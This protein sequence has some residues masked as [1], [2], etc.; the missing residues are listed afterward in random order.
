MKSNFG[1]LNRYWPALAQIGAAAE[2]YVYSDANACLYKLGMFG[3]RLILEIFAFEHIK[4]PALDNTHANRI[5][6]LKQEG[7]IPKK[8]DDILYALRK[9][10]NDAVH[11]GADSVEDAKI[12]L[13]MTYNLAV[14]FM[15]VYGDWGYIAPAFVMP[16]KVMQPNYEAII[17]EQE[18]KIAALSKQ[19]ESVS[20]AVSSKTSKERAE[21]GET[22]SESIKLSE[23]ETRYLIDEQ[24]R[25]YGWE[26]DT[27]HLRYSK[28]IRP[29]KGR[30]L[31]IAEWPTDSAIGKNG[32]ADYALFVELKLVGIVE[33]KKAAVDI[34]SVI[35]Y[36]CKEYAKGIKA[37][38]R[39][40]IINQWGAYKV[41][42]VFATNGRK[43][44]KQIETKSGIWYLDLRSGANAPK[45][46]Q[47]WISPQGLMEQLEKDIAAANAALQNT[48]FDLLRD[49]DGL[50]LHKYQIAAI[51]AAEQAV[52]DGKQTVLLSMATGTGKTRTILGMIYR[53]IK[54]DR[55]KRVLFLVDRTALGE[56][57]EDVFKE[58]KIEELMTLDS[59][60]NIKG[61][62][63]K[64]IDKETKIHIA[65]VQSLVKRILYPEGDTMLSVTDYDLIVVDEAHRGYILDKEMSE[66]EMLYRNQDD[67]ISKY[68]T[69]IE[70]F[71][72]VKIALTATPALHTTEIFGKPVFNYSY[73]EAVIDGYLVDHD[74]PHNIRTK[75]RVEGIN[76]KK[77]EQLVIYDP[78][79]GDVLNSAELEDDMK[80]EI[81]SFNRQIITENF[82][83]AVFEEI[84]WDFN[85]DGQGKTLIY[86]V[87]DNHADL[88]VKILKEIYAEGGVDNDTVMKIT[89]S[90][91]GGNKKKISEA[92]KRFKNESLPKVV[93]TV[94]LLTTGIDVPEITTLVFMRRI[95]SRILFEQM[96]GR[97][98]RLCPTIG[99][100]HFEIYDPVGVYESLQDVSN[101][102]PVVTNPSASFEDL[103]KGLEVAKTDEQ[104]AYQI[105]LIVAKLQRKRRNVSKKALEQFA[106]LTGGKDLTAF[107]EYL[108]N[109]TI[110]EAAAE[111]IR[112]RE[113]FSALDKDKPHR[114]R[115]VVIDNH[116]DELIDH[117]RGYGEGQKPE[118]YLEAFKE[119]IN[120]NMNAI[121]A[122]R[123]V[124]TK[125]SELTREALKSLKLELDRHDFTEKQLNSAWNEMT[126]Q[127]IV[128]DIIAF[129]RQQALG[130]IL[131]SHEQRVN[132]AFA[133]LRVNHD[134]NKTQLDWLKR[135]EKVLLEE[136]VLDE[137]IFE[138]GAFRNAGGFTIIDR[139]FG[140][141][142]REIMT[143]LNEYLYED[144]G[145][146]A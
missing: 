135:I 2:K 71:D 85:P 106:H 41:P 6:L 37:E 70:Y 38:H 31:A 121:A 59:I 23:A 76:Y 119:F 48:P 40:Y 105:D 58:V 126:N 50:N 45:A 94:D 134:F 65:T 138:V 108:N 145:H 139:R 24:L 142:L 4:E 17:K 22:A 115:P 75:L 42:F 79:T 28:G 143:E 136:S 88:I 89:G 103:M 7:L 57:A 144:G 74:A 26:A 104:L 53:F 123:T 114:K 125:P 137:Q 27:N 118:D 1:F 107:A 98:T 19:V 14:W 127:D 32:Y 86:A 54:N 99:K 52:I 11:A 30:N 69:V 141:K 36:Q 9:T 109:S 112:H 15:E 117:T 25:K 102:K 10:R 49:P 29:Q 8:I 3:E 132:H 92:I 93:V 63:E 21:K 64:E 20:T 16:E 61:L 100:T 35:D 84:A 90:I 111:L 78:V 95:K 18:E 101:M 120:N 128:A 43:Y 129:I 46:L 87:D 47:G 39:E 72:A 146:I 83:R 113:A 44:L 68:R 124:C 97:A 110:K 62:D 51:E 116:K 12:L 34:P 77:G 91:A 82:N 5:R 130:S 67:Y 13:T 55:F 33:A 96:L 66:T 131:V 80:F 56:Q 81:E 73:R 60:Y 122:L 140:G 133:K